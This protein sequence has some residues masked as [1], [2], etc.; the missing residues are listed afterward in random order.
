VLG[1]VERNGRFPESRWR[2]TSRD[3]K[4][5]RGSPANATRKRV[6]NRAAHTTLTESTSWAVERFVPGVPFELEVP[7]AL[8]LLRGNR[9]TRLSAYVSR[10]S[11]RDR[12]GV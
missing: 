11:W 12:A 8:L 7:S 4:S 1:F 10:S 5:G 6:G 9:A 2:L 3:G